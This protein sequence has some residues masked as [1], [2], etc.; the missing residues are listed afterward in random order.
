[1]R[2]RET[3]FG[4]AGRRRVKSDPIGDWWLPGGP[5]VDVF[6]MNLS[7]VRRLTGEALRERGI[8]AV[9]AIVGTAINAYGQLLVPWIRGVPD[10]LSAISAEFRN[11]PG[12]TMLSVFLAYAFPIGVGTY[13]SV[14]TRY[15]NR[16]D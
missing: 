10:P 6:T 15:K 13:T 1:L 11:R 3:F 2:A 7:L 9:A 14:V 8:Y 5:R 12:L 16:R 4:V